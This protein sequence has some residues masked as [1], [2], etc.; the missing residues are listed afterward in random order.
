MHVN[1]LDEVWKDLCDR[2]R[3]LRMVLRS[4]QAFHV[5]SGVE[6]FD[7]RVCFAGSAFTLTMSA[8]CVSSCGLRGRGE[9]SNQQ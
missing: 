9:R 4:I 1:I 5:W 7:H 2:C 8:V 6:H 3:L